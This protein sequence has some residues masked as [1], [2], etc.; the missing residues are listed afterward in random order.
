M[1]Q[2]RLTREEQKCHHGYYFGTTCEACAAEK[3]MPGFVMVPV[4]IIKNV[5]G[6]VRAADALDAL[7]K[8]KAP[9]VVPLKT[10]KKPL[11]NDL[12]QCVEATF[13]KYP[14][15]RKIKSQMEA[16]LAVVKEAN[17][18]DILHSGHTAGSWPKKCAG[19]RLMRALMRLHK[20][21]T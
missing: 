21:S 5:R 3:A 13:W 20:A 18:A 10:G 15:Q 19:C 17:N 12:L 9:K 7:D 6:L 8:P 1:R 11:A 14:E 4:D 2:D 16:V